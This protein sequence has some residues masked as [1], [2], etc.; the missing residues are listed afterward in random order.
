MLTYIQLVTKRYNWGL[1]ARIWGWLKGKGGYWIMLL[2]VN[3]MGCYQVQKL[4][5]QFILRFWQR[6]V[7]SNRMIYQHQ[8]LLSHLDNQN[9]KNNNQIH[10]RRL[11]LPLLIL[12]NTA[13]RYSYLSL[14]LIRIYEIASIVIVWVEEFVLLLETRFVENYW[15]GYLTSLISP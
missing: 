5:K 6:S 13:T 8:S 10:T 4:R 15:I 7:D 11:Y 3:I 14:S 2:F 9:N 12:Y 1:A